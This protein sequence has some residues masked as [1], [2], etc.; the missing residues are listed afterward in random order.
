MMAHAH[1]YPKLDSSYLI[2][3]VKNHFLESL[4]LEPQSLGKQHTTKQC[5]ARV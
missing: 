1:A 2:L 5:H 3:L 4:C